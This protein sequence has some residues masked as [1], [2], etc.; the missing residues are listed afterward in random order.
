MNKITPV[1]A[2]FYL[3]VATLLEAALA[4]KAL[5]LS[6]TYTNIAIGVLAASQVAIVGAIFLGLKYEPRAVV[7]IAVAS[8][9]FAVL[10]VVL[11]LGSLG[12]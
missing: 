11:A 5:S 7:G 6:T 12:H 1:A 4:N 2:W 3:I 9:F 10:A 8:L